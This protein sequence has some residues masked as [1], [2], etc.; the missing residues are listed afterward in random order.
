M[1]VKIKLT[2][3]KETEIDDCDKDLAELKWYAQKSGDGKNTTFYA[4]RKGIQIRTQRE[5]IILSRVILERMLNKKLN[6]NETADHINND[7]LDNKRCNLRLATQTE[8]NRNRRIQGKPKTSDFKGVY[9]SENDKRWRSQIK[10]NNTTIHLGNFIDE[11]NAAKA[12]DEAA[13]KYFGEYAKLNFKR[14]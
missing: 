1:I 4:C 13:I 14:S 6:K 7:A 10:T 12:Y 9:W 11:I 3:G 2:Q 5:T 8:N